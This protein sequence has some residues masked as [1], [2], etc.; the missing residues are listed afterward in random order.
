MQEIVVNNVVVRQT[1]KQRAPI[2]DNDLTSQREL[3]GHHDRP[4]VISEYREFV[5][6]HSGELPWNARPRT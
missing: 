4:S 1:H 2:P 5:Q 3:P 6:R